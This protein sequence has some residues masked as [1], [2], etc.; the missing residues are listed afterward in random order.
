[1]GYCR[2][3]GKIIMDKLKELITHYMEFH[4][5]EFDCSDQTEEETFEMVMENVVSMVED[6][7]YEDYRKKENG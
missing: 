5:N 7:R 6:Y 3:G 4:M 2:Y 1:M